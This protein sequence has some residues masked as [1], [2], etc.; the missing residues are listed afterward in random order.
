MPQPCGMGFVMEAFVDVDNAVDSITRQSRTCFLVYLN[1]APVYWLSKKQTSA[2]TSLFVSEFMVMKQCT[3]YIRGL[4][5]KLW[6]MG[7]PCTAPAF[8]FGN[9]QSVLANTKI[10]DS[11]TKKKSQSIAYHFVYKCAARDE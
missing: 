1:S 4:R 11:T 9:I 7:I 3:E 2:E 10:P 8:I 5:Y 6:I